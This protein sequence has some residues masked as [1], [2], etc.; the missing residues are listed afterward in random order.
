MDNPSGVGVFG[1]GGGTSGPGTGS[2][3]GPA[4][5]PRSPRGRAGRLSGPPLAA[6]RTFLSPVTRAA[7]QSAAATTAVR[8]SSA[9]VQVCA[10]HHHYHNHHTI[11]T[12]RQT[13]SPK[14]YTARAC[15]FYLWRLVTWSLIFYLFFSCI[16]ACT[17]FMP[18]SLYNHHPL[19]CFYRFLGFA[20]FRPRPQ[21]LVWLPSCPLFSPLHT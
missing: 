18:L 11:K 21:R 6:T 7:A 4:A 12:F 13:K 1:S 14:S 10:V 19:V 15:T 20:I 16:K 8:R 17:P 3:G 5:R 9:G 2:C